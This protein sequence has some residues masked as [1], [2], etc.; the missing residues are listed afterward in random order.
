VDNADFTLT[1]T[2]NLS[3]TLVAN[4]TGAGNTYTVLAATGSGDGGLRLDVLDDDSILNASGIPLGGAGAGNGGFTAGEAYTLDKTVPSVTGSLRADPNPTTAASVNFSVVFSEPVTG[5]D[6]GDFFLAASGTLS[7]AAI[8]GI[9]GSGYLYTVSVGTGSGDGTLRLDV[10]DDDSIVDAAGQPLAGAGIGNGN[11]NTGEEYS[12]S[13]TPV[14]LIV[15]SLRSNGANDGWVLESNE[16][17]NQGGSRNANGNVFV[18]GDNAQDQQFRAILDFPTHYLPDNAVI[19]RVLLMIKKEGVVGT[20]PFSTHQNIL[21]DIHSGAFG[22]LGPFPYRGLQVGDFQSPASMDSAGM[23]QNNPLDGW[24][25]TWLD[26][27]SFQFVNL[28]G[29]TQFRLRFQVDDNDD[30]GIDHL[31]FYS[32]DQK[33]IADRPRLVIEYYISR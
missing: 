30:N 17:S 29:F 2:G 22:Y 23:I 28:N 12:F 16:N 15:E 18:L 8:T 32:G 20:D 9:S 21:V 6:T 3:G 14:N 7:G 13:R 1:T 10:L 27:A 31:R 19:T 5:V 26:P 33:A 11:F 24:H 25:W 4:V